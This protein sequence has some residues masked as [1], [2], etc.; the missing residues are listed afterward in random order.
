M[1][2]DHQYGFYTQ[3]LIQSFLEDG[4]DIKRPATIEDICIIVGTAAENIIR[5]H[6]A[7]RQSDNIVQGLL[8]PKGE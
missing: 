7:Q 5:Q 2:K 4:V 3:G 8:K 1:K 6:E